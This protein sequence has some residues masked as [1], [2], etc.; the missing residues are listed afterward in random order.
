[1]VVSKF[2]RN[3]GNNLEGYTPKHDK[4]GIEYKLSDVRL[5][6]KFLNVHSYFVPLNVFNVK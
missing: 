2:M 4:K 6:E 5:S 3:M 1:M